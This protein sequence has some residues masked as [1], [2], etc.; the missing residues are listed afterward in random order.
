M[1][2]RYDRS[3]R[4]YNYQ[5]A[6]TVRIFIC[7]LKYY[8]YVNTWLNY[9]S[10][11]ASSLMSDPPQGLSSN[12]THYISSSL[13]SRYPK[14]RF[15]KFK[16]LW[17]AFSFIDNDD[18]TNSIASI[19][20]TP[21]WPL[22]VVVS[23]FVIFIFK[24]RTSF[25]LFRLFFS[26]GISFAI[27]EV[28]LCPVNEKTSLKCVLSFS[29]S[30]VGIDWI[31][32]SKRIASFAWKLLINSEHPDTLS[33][34]SQ[35]SFHGSPEKNC[36]QNQE[37]IINEHFRQRWP[38]K[39]LTGQNKPYLK[40]NLLQIAGSPILFSVLSEAISVLFLIFV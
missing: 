38:R 11:Q 12:F 26:N 21:T 7:A 31:F 39:I 37:K 19:E 15:Y 10:Q 28:I 2:Y 6:F 18:I 24:R 9:Y 29:T 17:A 22:F 35:V 30:S 34:G 23:I 5:F 1:N 13:P 32:I 14:H 16:N 36:N 3:K 33:Y 4:I 25:V 40:K 8:G 20:R 27:N